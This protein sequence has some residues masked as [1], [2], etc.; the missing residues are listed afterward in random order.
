VNWNKGTDRTLN[1]VLGF[2]TLITGRRCVSTS[3]K[4]K[5]V[6]ELPIVVPRFLL[7]H[8]SLALMNQPFP[9]YTPSPPL[10]HDLSLSSSRL[11]EHLRRKL[12]LHRKPTMNSVFPSN[13]NSSPIAVRFY[14]AFPRSKSLSPNQLD[15]YMW[16]NNYGSR[17]PR[18]P[19]TS[20]SRIPWAF[21]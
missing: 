13:T 12:K 7:Q 10:R 18:L 3:F 2:R 4:R 5:T 1:T 19:Y 17:H 9:I 8:L 15:L 21:R 14:I 20:S 16:D 11:Q 6:R